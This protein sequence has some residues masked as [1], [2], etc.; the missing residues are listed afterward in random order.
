[1]FL[2]RLIEISLLIC[3]SCVN[4]LTF[5]L[6]ESLFLD[7]GSIDRAEHFKVIQIQA[8]AEKKTLNE[9]YAIKQLSLINERFTS[10]QTE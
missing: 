2:N 5:L 4:I 10:H 6:N 9:D 3:H 1:M 7:N 8:K